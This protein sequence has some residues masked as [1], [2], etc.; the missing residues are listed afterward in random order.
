[1]WPMIE[2][3]PFGN[4][5]PKDAQKMIIGSFPIGK[6]SDPG[7]RHEIKPHEFNFFFGGERNLLWKLLSDCY[8][9]KFHSREDIVRFLETEK[10]AIGDVIKSCRRR[11]G[12]ASDKDLLEIEWN[13]GLME[14]IRKNHISQIYFTSKQVERWFDALFNDTEGLERFLLPSPSGQAA[15]SMARNEDYKRWKLTHSQ[16][17]MYDYLLEKYQIF[18]GPTAEK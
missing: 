10:I 2:H 3:H 12:G 7:R 17:K 11:G 14:V 15:R 1:M 4:F 6:F 8:G 9:V 13:T 16:K 5:V 18:F